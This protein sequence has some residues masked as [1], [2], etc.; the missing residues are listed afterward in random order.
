MRKDIIVMAWLLFYLLSSLSTV[1]GEDLTAD[2]ILKRADRVRGAGK[3]VVI[4]AIISSVKPEKENI[5]GEFEI[6][7]KYQEKKTLVKFLF[8]PRDKGKFFLMLGDDFWIYLPNTRKP[9]RISPLQ[10]LLG[11]A[12]YSDIARPTYGGDYYAE[13]LRMEKSENKECF[14][15]E[16]KAK[17]KKV[18]YH[19]VI[20]WVQKENFHPIKANFYTFSG[21]LMK[22]AFFKGYEYKPH[23]KQSTPTRLVIIDQIM[24]DSETIIEYTKIEPRKIPDKLFSRDYLRRMR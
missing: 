10:R 14:V 20:Y 1:L 18:A 11:N 12:S 5:T 17:N 4:E 19:R 21:K 22:T 2:E 7:S 6:L 9:V 15:L 13:F 23:L 3:S 24:R 8:P 16:L